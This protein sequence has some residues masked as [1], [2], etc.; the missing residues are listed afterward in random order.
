MRLFMNENQNFF[1][2]WTRSCPYKDSCQREKC[3]V[4]YFGTDISYDQDSDN[5][6]MLHEV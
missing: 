1:F 6:N 2:L 3:A 4:S 5:D